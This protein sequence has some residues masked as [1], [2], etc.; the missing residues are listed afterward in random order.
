MAIK[1]FT[2]NED[3]VDAIISDYNSSIPVDLVPDSDASRSIGSSSKEFTDV[4]A[5][6]VHASDVYGTVRYADIV[7]Q[8]K[9]CEKCGNKFEEGDAVQLVVNKVV[10]DDSEDEGTY[11]L[12]I[13]S[14]C[15]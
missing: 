6:N 12:P 10:D 9:R 11:L 13:H 1:S 4:Y 3:N 5:T 2:N 15:A 8:E 14:K 7:F